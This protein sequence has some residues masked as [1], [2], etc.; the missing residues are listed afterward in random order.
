MSEP[1]TP[2][3]EGEFDG[4]RNPDIDRLRRQNLAI[5]MLPSRAILDLE[6]F[7]WRMG[8][9]GVVRACIERAERVVTRNWDA[10]GSPCAGEGG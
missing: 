6:Q 2:R 10:N 9:S 8:V 7:E 4:L 3:M 1:A 5:D